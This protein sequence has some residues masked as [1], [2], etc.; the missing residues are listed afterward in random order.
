MGRFVTEVSGRTET[1]LT[2]IGEERERQFTKWGPQ[3][4]RDAT[5]PGQYLADSRGR[6]R[7]FAEWRDEQRQRTDDMAEAGQTWWSDI[8]LEEVF[9]AL[10]ENDP[11]ALR[12]ELVQVAAVATAWVEDIDSRADHHEL[13]GEG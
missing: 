6:Q 7:L 5:G 4:H 9:E 12:K 13:G 1:V 11:A 8:L 3:H 10:S 2:D